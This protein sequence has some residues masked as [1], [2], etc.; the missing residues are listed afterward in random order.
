MRLRCSV[1]AAS[2]RRW[3]SSR[4][5]WKKRVSD[6]VALNLLTCLSHAGDENARQKLRTQLTKAPTP[7]AQMLAAAKLAQLGQEDGA[8]TCASGCASRVV[9]SWWRL[10]SGRS[11]RAWRGGPVSTGAAR[12][13]LPSA[14]QLAVEGLG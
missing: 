9:S 10:A 4:R 5:S 2:P 13:R 8:P 12:A 7:D 3:R 11:R 1:S 6:T 14:K